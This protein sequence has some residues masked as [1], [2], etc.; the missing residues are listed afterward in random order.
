MYVIVA[1]RLD[2]AFAMVVVSGYMSNPGK[3][4]CRAVKCILRYL[5]GTKDL[6]ICFGK[7]EKFVLGFI[8]E[9]FIVE[10]VALSTTEAEYV[11]AKEACKEALWLMHLVGELGIDMKILVLHCDSQSAIMLVRKPVFYAKTNHIEVKYHFIWSVLDDKAIELV[12]MASFKALSFAEPRPYHLPTRFNACF[13]SLCP[14]ACLSTKKKLVFLGSP[15]VAA[16]VLDQLLIAADG[17]T[18]SFEVA[19]VV[20]Q[21]PAPKGRGQKLQ[22]S[23]VAELAL[24]K[25]I[26][27][28]RIYWPQRAGEEAFLHQMSDLGPDLCITASYGNILPKRFLK[29][30]V[31]GTVNIHPS[32]LPLYR[33]AAPVQRTIEDGAHETGVTVAFTVRALD[34]GPIIASKA[35]SVDDHIKAPE[36]LHLLFQEGVQLLLRE[37]PSILNGTASQHAQGQDHARATHA[38]KVTVDEAWLNFDQPAIVLHNKV[39][40]FADWPGTKA[41]FEVVNT[42]GEA[43]QDLDL[44]I[45]TTKPRIDTSAESNV[46]HFD[47][48]RHLLRHEKSALLVFCGGDSVLEI[49]ELQP[50][51]K[52][53]MSAKDFSNGLRGQQLR[54][55]V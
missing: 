2:I 30:P 51:G 9:S 7:L 25:K 37:L 23:P 41:K 39:R 29:I 28:N 3:K 43:T 12:K 8:D 1:A 24:E 53:I 48:N 44:K 21:P 10:C 52:R 11:A 6:C 42:T 31:N 18:S 35:M 55:A 5:K 20:T 4:H 19:A 22:L 36:L 45:I 14:S 54:I 34:A 50:P 26:P 17:E 40:A 32:L 16:T 47:H 33:G 15:K 46:G 38:P 27:E 13:S 49:L